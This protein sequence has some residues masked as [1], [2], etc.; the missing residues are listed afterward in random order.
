MAHLNNKNQLIGSLGNLVF[1]IVKGKMVI[2]TKP[3]R[4]NIK[5]TKHTKSAASDFGSSSHITKKINSGMQEFVQNYHS[6][7]MHNRLRTKILRAMRFQSAL[8]LGRK[9][10]W[11]GTPKL[12]E[13]FEF[14]TASKYNEFSELNLINW[15]VDE[16]H[17]IGFQQQRFIPKKH[18]HWLPFTG[19]VEVCYWLSAFRKSDYKP[20]QQELFKLEVR[21]NY[22][23]VPL[24]TF[25]SN[26]FPVNSL[27]IIS[28]GL[29][30]YKEDPVLGKL[31]LN[32][33]TCHPVRI[34]KV[35][36]L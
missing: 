21:P 31:L 10:L 4:K 24:Q 3:E 1:K 35:I 22:T 18:L 15:Q 28:A 2:Q 12:L 13:G 27:V 6:S 29:L 23:E 5:Q 9:N 33:K 8:P 14:N 16:Q 11:D 7:D 19:Q 17:R 34:V 26:P 20:Y 36:K 25:Q 30:Y 32:G